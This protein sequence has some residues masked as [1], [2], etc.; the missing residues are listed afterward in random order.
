MTSPRI[1][2]LAAA[3]IGWT[4]VGYPGVLWLVARLRPHP[5]PVVPSDD[6]LPTVALIVPA[7]AEAGVIADKVRN[8]RALAYPRDRLELVIACDGSTDGTPAAARAAGADSVLELP[9]GGKIAA[10]D[11]AV[12]QTDAEI[13][14]FSD[15]NALWEPGALRELVA[16]FADPRVGYVCGRVRFVNPDG[17][18]NR[19]GIYWRYEMAIRERES[20]L[21]SVTAGNGAIYAVRRSAYVRVDP[22]MGHDLKLP[23]TL[24]RGGWRAVEAAGARAT[25]RM[26]PDVEGEARR[27]RRMQ[28]HAWAIVLRGGLLDPRGWPPAYTAMMVSHRWLRYAAPLLHLVALVAAPR[29]WRRLQLAALAA[30]A[31]PAPLTGQDPRGPLARSHALLRYYVLMQRSTLFGLADHM[32]HGTDAGWAPPEGTRARIPGVRVAEREASDA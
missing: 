26:V 20:A 28:S 18:S 22:V 24:V 17:G 8:V 30:V 7:Y 27:K 11:A 12:A 15:A 13:V 23:F 16:P 31:V 2:R 9:R 5:R 29:R 3:L 4:S 32:R 19:E 6:A 14:A 25:E 21:C 10:Q 1:F